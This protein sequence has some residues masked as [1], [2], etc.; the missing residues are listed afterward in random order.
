MPVVDYPYNL[1]RGLSDFWT[2]FFADADQL[3]ALYRGT[4]IQLGQA[5]LDLLSSVLSVSLKDALVFDREYYSLV[6]VR[7]DEVSFSALDG[8][9]TFPLPDPV[10]DFASLDNRVVEPT[11]SLEPNR[12]LEV[13]DRVVRF[14]ADPTDPAG[15]GVPL[16][17]YARR[18]LDVE[19]GGRFSDPGIADWRTTGARKGDTL[20]VLDVGSDGTQRKRA[21]YSIVLVR[22]DGLRVS[23]AT[24]LPT[25]GTLSPINYVV[26]RVPQA[27]EVIA[28]AFT[29]SGSE[30]T[31]AHSR[32]DVGSVRVFA[33][34]PGG[35][36]V[37]EGVD[38][39]I[40]YE[41]GLV[42]AVT[43]WIGMVSGAGTFSI[44][45]RWRDEV[46]PSTG[47][48][49]RLATDGSIE[50]VGTARVL[51]IALW[52]PDAAVDRR[53]LANNYG[54]LIGRSLPS[55]EAYRAFLAG[56]FQLYVLGPVLERIESA[57]NVVLGYSVVRDDGETFSSIDTSDPA[58]DRLLTIRPPSGLVA[59]Y[60]FPK[61]TPF[62]PDLVE[63]L[64]LESF[65]PLTTVVSVVDWI[66]TPDWWHGAVIPEQLFTPPEGALPSISR[67]TASPFYVENVIG[68]SDSPVIGDPGLV[69]GA[70]ETGFIPP[71]GQ[72]V[73]R[74]RLAFVLMDRYLK[75]HT[76][77]I[78]FNA[79][80]LAAAV[81]DALPQSLKDL[82]EL[83]LTSRP[84]H[85][86][87]FTTPETFFRDEIQVLEGSISFNR[88]LGS[89]VFGPDKVV[90]A[91]AAP[92]IGS[93]TWSVGDYFKYELL[94]LSTSFPSVGVPVTLGGAPAAP[95]HGRLVLVHVPGTIAGHAL[96][97]NVD[98]AVDYS[99][100]SVTRLTAWTSTT[101]SVAFR[102]LNIGNLSDA[103]G[104]TDDM[105][106]LINGVD[107]A[108]ITAAFDPAAAGWDGTPNPPTAPRDLGMVER[109]LIVNPH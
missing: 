7:E 50:G 105:P 103:I 86:F 63:G 56:I 40:N 77:S 37:V 24:P 21:D 5:Y 19:V 22:Q 88:L 89:R 54:S 80:E 13:V 34:G 65:S 64:V 72:P 4:V 49:P 100:R 96:V 59:T 74:H 104:D 35:A 91:D 68:A 82:N 58:F 98:Y 60:T 9:W 30:A 28:E 48:S 11:A 102:Q 95:R 57:L 94:T 15:D 81:G 87:P 76:F 3:D 32:L 18:A 39:L 52:A 92:V 69:I 90:F 99:A 108:L 67:R 38:Y 41:Q 12:D 47:P 93:G 29:L 26:L 44:D 17:G 14:H 79:I 2:R 73:L 42:V 107:P 97:E 84:S 10:V 78:K 31:L 23:V 70:D 83:I 6:T 46:L 27:P 16:V 85:T 109:A 25:N 51:Q 36:D 66:Q 1:L 62:R 33:K 8:R 106:I 20:R 61:G 71:P 55:S 101:V 75:H 43:A 45:Y 53:T